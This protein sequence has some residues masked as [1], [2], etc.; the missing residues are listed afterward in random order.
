MYTNFNSP[1]FLKGSGKGYV[2]EI[3][4]FINRRKEFFWHHW[5]GSEINEMAFYICP[6]LSHSFLFSLSHPF[7]L[8]AFLY[9]PLRTHEVLKSWRICCCRSGRKTAYSWGSNRTA[10]SVVLDWPRNGWE[11]T[12]LQLMGSLWPMSSS[13]PRFSE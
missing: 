7:I 1:E 11:P 12:V 10:A 3:S 4:S 2:Q 8:L 13:Q 5:N 9:S 6:L